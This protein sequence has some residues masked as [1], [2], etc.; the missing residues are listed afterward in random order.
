MADDTQNCSPNV[1]YL[2]SSIRLGA[3]NG[4]DGRGRMH[5]KI[6]NKSS[7][8]IPF[9]LFSDRTFQSLFTL[10]NIAGF[11]ESESF[12]LIEGGLVNGG[13]IIQFTLA[14]ICQFQLVFT[15]STPLTFSI[16]KRP[17]EFFLL[18]QNGD[19]ILLQNGIDKLLI[20]GLVP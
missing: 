4:D 2:D 1:L 12:D 6:S 14:G 17:C 15:L 13:L 10:A 16:F 18:Q 9:E 20:Q 7:E 8:L 19:K 5:T 3:T 11:I